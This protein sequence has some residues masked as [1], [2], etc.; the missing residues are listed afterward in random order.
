MFVCITLQLCPNQKDFSRFNGNCERVLCK[1][2]TII[3]IFADGGYAGQ[4]IE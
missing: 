3:K 1:Y 2:P 4:F